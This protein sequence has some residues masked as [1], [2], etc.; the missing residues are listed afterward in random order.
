MIDWNI[1]FSEQLKWTYEFRNHIYK[2]INLETKTNLLEIGCGTG[3]LLKE[4]G[5][6]FKLELYGIDIDKNRLKISKENLKK[7][8]I[9]A[10]LQYMD[11]LNNNFEDE[12]FEVIITHYLFLWIKDLEKCFNEIH[13]ILKKEGILLILAEPDYGGL[14]GFPETGL[15]DAL[16]SN[17]TNSG[18]DAKVGRKLN[19]FFSQ[20]FDIIEEYCT[21]IPW[22]SNNN[23]DNLLKEMKFFKK[24]LTEQK[25]DFIQ[26]KNSIE[27]NKYFLFI[28]VFTYYLRKI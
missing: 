14:I 9:K 26:T 4:I 19:Q 1:R 3:A 23:K 8:G 22:V 27:L 13:R 25:W 12:R 6:K 11:I 24:I 17:L 5:K 21:S 10:N 7:E 2:I 18:A 28:P 20:K 15:K 16:I